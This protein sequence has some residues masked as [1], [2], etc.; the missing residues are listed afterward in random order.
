MAWL[1]KGQSTPFENEPIEGLFFLDGDLLARKLD[2]DAIKG[3]KYPTI[4]F[5]SGVICELWNSSDPTNAIVHIFGE[6]DLRLKDTRDNAIA[7]AAHIGKLGG[8]M[9]R[10]KGERGIEVIGSDDF[11]VDH[12]LI[13][14]DAA[15]GR[16]SDVTLIGEEETRIPT[17]PLLDQASRE[18][19][20]ALR[21][22]EKLGLDTVAPVKFF[23][24]DAQ[25]TWYASEFDGEDVFFGLVNG[26][27]LEFGNFFLSE[28]EA[29][30]GPLGLP[31]E[32]DLHYEPKT[33]RELQAMHQEERHRRN[34]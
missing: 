32:R 33:F 31:V 19:L 24:P 17:P 13:S 23:S 14:Y 16:M 3:Q 29:T 8:Y 20:P 22:W 15:Q 30:R 28:L 9:V 2:Q 4:V 25:W 21:S 1:E 10:P 12:I 26:Y 11:P 7:H 34:T 27:E 5:P 18:A 6:M